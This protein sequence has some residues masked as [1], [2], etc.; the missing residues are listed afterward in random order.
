VQFRV[1]WRCAG[2]RGLRRAGGLGAVLRALEL[3][4]IGSVPVGVARTA[5][6]HSLLK[7]SPL[8]SAE[9][10]QNVA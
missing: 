9:I 4:G 2:L 6:A 7:N 3:D 10:D 8:S 1:A 5:A